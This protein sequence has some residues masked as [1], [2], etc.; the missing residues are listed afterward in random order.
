MNDSQ[1]AEHLLNEMGRLSELK[2]ENLEAFAPT[3]NALARP[4]FEALLTC[5]DHWKVSFEHEREN[6]KRLRRLVYDAHNSD[7]PAVKPCHCYDCN[8]TRGLPKEQQP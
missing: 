2:G 1:S 6:V 3:F 5:R 4:V 7:D 8:L